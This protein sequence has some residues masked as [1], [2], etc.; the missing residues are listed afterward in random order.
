[1]KRVLLLTF[2]ACLWAGDAQHGAVLVQDQNC[3]E[4][5]TV[6]AQGAGHEANATAPDL[7]AN[8]P[9]AALAYTPAVLASALWNHTPAML[10]EVTA[11]LVERPALTEADWADVFAYL[12]SEQIFQFPA[13]T[14]RGK[15]VF[16]LKGCA[17]CHSQTGPNSTT[18]GKGLG[19]PVSEWRSEEDPATLVYQMWNH[20]STMKATLAARKQDWPKLDGR[21]FGDLAAYIQY[22][23]KLAPESYLTLPE[24]ATGKLAFGHNC[25]QCHQGPLALENRLANKTF[26]DIGAGVWNH[27]PLMDAET[28]SALSE[29][30]MR[31]IVA[32]VWDLQYQ[33]PE[34][35]VTLGELAFAAKGCAAC[36][37]DPKTG[38]VVSPHPGKV[39]TSFSI[40]AIAWGS[41]SRMHREMWN[42]SEP[43]PTLSR[44]HIRLGRI[45][46]LHLTKVASLLR[47]L[48]DDDLLLCE[49]VGET[50]SEFL[51]QFLQEACDFGAI[52]QCVAGARGF[53]RADSRGD[54][55]G[56][57][58]EGAFI[59]EVVAYVNRQSL[60]RPQT[61][62]SPHGVTLAANL[63]R[64]HFPNPISG[65][66]AQL[67]R[68]F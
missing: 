42:R 21:D 7:A 40:S 32:Y 8:S 12:Y 35:N 43:W 37:T 52:A 38:M 39:F 26:L 25:A 1:V 13:Q 60:R 11:K 58:G 56:Q 18:A 64:K 4:C 28:F 5:H 54:A 59:R 47:P 57:R 15:D 20:A 31:R 62:L 67:A 2:T 24:A 17:D 53:G 51:L 48:A 22:V 68:M 16:R 61:P 50:L 3:L 30:E 14:R 23:Q 9:S 66:D 34:G 10:N 36:H 44:E 6:N 55:L 27:V 46:E 29:P 45:F 49:S 65:D 41:S 33:G 63:A 19:A